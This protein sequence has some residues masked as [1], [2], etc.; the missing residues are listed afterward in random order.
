MDKKNPC[1]MDRRQFLGRMGMGY[2]T[3]LSLMALHPLRLSAR[4]QTT[5][6]TQTGTDA[7]E[8]GMTYRTQRGSTRL[9]SMAAAPTRA[10]RAAHSVAIRARNTMWPPRCPTST[11]TCGR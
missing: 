6:S 9:P 3:A 8:G 7:P 11:A 1:G 2:A 5:T 10:S 4:S